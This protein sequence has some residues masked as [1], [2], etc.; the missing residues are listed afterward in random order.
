[1]IM[2]VYHTCRIVV[3]LVS[4]SIVLSSAGLL[5]RR[6]LF[7]EGNMLSRELIQSYRPFYQRRYMKPAGMFFNGKLFVLLL[8]VRLLLGLVIIVYA[9]LG[10]V[11]LC[12][13][14]A[15]LLCQ[16]LF[17]IR[18]EVA[19][20]G[21]DQLTTLVLL[22]MTIAH[23]NTASTFFPAVSL[24]FLSLLM[25]IGYTTAGLCKLKKKWLNGEELEQIMSTD[26]LG[27]AMLYRFL[28]KHR[29]AGIALSVFVCF[30]ELLLGIAFLLPPGTC[31]VILC[32]GVVLHLGIGLF[33]G[34]NT[35]LPAF[36][37]TYPAILYTC[38]HGISLPTG[39]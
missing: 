13:L 28:R 19:L 7:T 2:D 17:I 9:S 11:S 10:H 22:A 31:I 3:I 5:L 37:A 21:A 8:F 35:F 1:M 34:L 18:H 32:L 27:N 6:D 16:L 14:I 4:L 26:V 33:M 29:W 23:I 15:G 39:I 25:A 12:L 36:A 30:A 20:M 24:S 38:I